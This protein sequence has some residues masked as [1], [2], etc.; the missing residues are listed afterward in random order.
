M[1]TQTLRSERRGHLGL[2]TLDKTNLGEVCGRV[3][4]DEL[5][6]ACSVLND[7]QSVRVVIVTGTDGGFA[8]GMAPP[9]PDGSFCRLASI[10][11]RV[12]KPLIAAID[13]ECFDQGLEM[14]LACDLRL[15]SSG[16]RFGMTYVTQGLLPWD[17]GTQRLA[18]SVG[19]AHALR[20]LLTGETIQSVEAL[21]IG[22]IQE[23][24]EGTDFWGQALERAATV[25]LGAPLAAGYAKEAILSGADLALEHGLRLEADLSILLHSTEDRAQGIRSFRDRHPPQYEG[26]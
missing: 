23:V 18:R 7:D 8:T 16:S 21:R 22:L 24:I 17:G 5:S 6:S 9:A 19:R 12:R 2:I 26:Q 25:A 1:G 14:A 11:A 4:E 15:A 20:I 3:L 13:G 10:L